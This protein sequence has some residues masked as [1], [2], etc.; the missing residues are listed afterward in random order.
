MHAP[1]AAYR[2]MP[3][4]QD[5]QERRHGVLPMAKVPAVVGQQHSMSCWRRHM[6]PRVYARPSP[7]SRAQTSEVR[8]AAVEVR[9]GAQKQQELRTLCRIW[10]ALELAW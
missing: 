2:G 8:A 7:Y 5:A 1:H 3:A 6:G 10:P 4:C 9:H